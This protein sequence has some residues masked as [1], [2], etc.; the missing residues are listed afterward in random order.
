MRA[1]AQLKD[2]PSVDSFL[3][4]AE[5]L[6][7]PVDAFFEKVFVMT[8]D[9]AVRRNRLALLRCVLGSRV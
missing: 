3:A 8:E 1:V 7:V 9:E 2:G 5:Q 4:A 6:L